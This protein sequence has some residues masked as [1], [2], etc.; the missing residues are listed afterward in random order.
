MANVYIKP[1]YFGTQVEPY[2]VYFTWTDRLPDTSVFTDA[3]VSVT[4]GTLSDFSFI[5]QNH[6][7]TT[8]QATLTPPTTGSGD[9]TIT[10]AANVYDSNEA[11]TETIAYAQPCL[12]YTSPSPRD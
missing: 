10:V 12:L 5:F 2:T 11:S 7:L 6:D 8:Y 1:D 3:N 4:N 9:T